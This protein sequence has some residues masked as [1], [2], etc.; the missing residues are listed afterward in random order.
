[1]SMILPGPAAPSADRSQLPPRWARVR[2]KDVGDVQL[3]RQRAPEHHSAATHLTGLSLPA[4]E[5]EHGAE[6]L[7]LEGL[8]GS[9]GG[10]PPQAKPHYVP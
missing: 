2:V 4:S 8:G 7:G 3:R 10:P 1:M 5:P 9:Q 6:R